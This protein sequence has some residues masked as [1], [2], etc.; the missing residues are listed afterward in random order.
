[1]TPRYN[2][3]YQ[4]DSRARGFRNLDVRPFR[5]PDPR[6]RKAVGHFRELS[7]PP[8]IPRTQKNVLRAWPRIAR[9]GVFA[10]YRRFE[11]L[12]RSAKRSRVRI[13]RIP[14]D[15]RRRRMRGGKPFRKGKN[16]HCLNG[17]QTPG[18]FV[19]AH[20]LFGRIQRSHTGDPRRRRFRIAAFMNHEPVLEF[21]LNGFPDRRKIPWRKVRGEGREARTSN[22]A[23]RRP[24]RRM[25][26]RRH[27]EHPEPPF[28]VPEVG[29][30]SRGPHDLLRQREMSERSPWKRFH[31]LNRVPN[32]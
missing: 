6:I 12:G 11:K 26:R 30:R 31:G 3:D 13:G 24:Y 10:D 23:R 32:G 17:S 25:R 22:G 18:E 19:L 4:P 14:V 9:H 27:S 21:G 29:R 15:G 7:R 8:E 28:G 5:E 1:M 16:V 2:G 20:G